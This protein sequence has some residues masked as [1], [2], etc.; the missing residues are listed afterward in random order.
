MVWQNENWLA[1]DK[2]ADWLTVP[3]RQG[4][5]D[6]RPCLGREL[7]RRLGLRLWPVHRLD[8]EVS[9]LVLFALSAEAHR[10][11][12][13]WF[14]DHLVVKTYGALSLGPVAAQ[15]MQENEW[16]C[17]LVRGKRRAFVAEHGQPSLTMAQCLGPDGDFWRWKL[18]PKTGRSHQLRVEMYRHG[19][20]ILGD[21]L[22]GGQVWD[23]PGI[24]LRAENLNFAAVANEQRLQLPAQLSLA[25]E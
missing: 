6:M 24:A 13:R 9:G 21:E 22:Y 14:E 3:S 1:V 18:Q 15:F 2:P 17:K 12:N 25:K 23:Q 5:D 7:E 11:A 16:K 10:R 19:Y 4:T 8:F 20:S